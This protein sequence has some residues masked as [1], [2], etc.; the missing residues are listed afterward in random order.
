MIARVAI[1][2]AIIGLGCG[3][4]ALG[5]RLQ[6]RWASHSVGSSPWSALKPGVPA[7]VYFWSE[8]CLPC[9]T[10]QSPA[11]NQLE[12]EMGQERILIVSVN[13]LQQPEI[14]QEW[15]VFSVPT[16]FILDRSGQPQQV[17]H[18]IVGVERLRRQIEMLS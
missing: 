8:T 9:K 18:G 1:T 11:L 5:R 3:L 10:V 15:G 17:N 6:L 13:A 2:L 4:Y 12:Q 14:A 16:T 7:V